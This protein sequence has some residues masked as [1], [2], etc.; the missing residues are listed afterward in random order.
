V[1]SIDIEKAIAIR[2]GFDAVAFIDATQTAPFDL[3]GVSGEPSC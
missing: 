3:I 2:L 1:D